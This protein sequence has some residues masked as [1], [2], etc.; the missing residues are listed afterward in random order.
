MNWNTI[1][2]DF[3]IYGPAGICMEGNQEALLKS[4]SLSVES[5]PEGGGEFTYVEIGAGGGGTLAFMAGNIARLSETRG[6]KWRVIGVD[7]E[8]G[9]SF[10]RR[11][12]E[13]N[14]GG[15]GLNWDDS[16]LEFGGISVSMA[17]GDR[18]FKTFVSPVNLALIDGDHS[19][20]HV[21]RD[22]LN[23]EKLISDKGVVL[24]HDIDEDAQSHPPAP[25]EVVEALKSLGLWDGSRIGWEKIAVTDPPGGNFGLLIARRKSGGVFERPLRVY[26]GCGN[27]I[28]PG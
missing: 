24:F 20:E 21:K 15:F 18:F 5:I 11:L 13:E 26:L 1:S 23:I 4:L 10:D 12:I 9:W 2:T 19:C 17:G 28:R 8:N 3:M 6:F 7:I 27:D 22:F 16:N 25:I 14:C